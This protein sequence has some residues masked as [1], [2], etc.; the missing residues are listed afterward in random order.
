[1]GFGSLHGGGDV[2]LGSDCTAGRFVVG[3]WV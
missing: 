2:V 1:M 3:L